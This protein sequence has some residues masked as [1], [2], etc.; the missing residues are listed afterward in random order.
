[1][2]AEQALASGQGVSA[3]RRAN[4]VEALVTLTM[5]MNTADPGMGCDSK[6]WNWKAKLEAIKETAEPAEKKP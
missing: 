1:M 2:V 5:S 4:C 6:A 3:E